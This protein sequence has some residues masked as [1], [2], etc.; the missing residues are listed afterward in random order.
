M[1]R[2]NLKNERAKRLCSLQAG[3]PWR[4]TKISRIRKHT[5]SICPS[6][7]KGSLGGGAPCVFSTRAV[8]KPWIPL[9]L[10]MSQHSIYCPFARSE[11][12]AL[13]WPSWHGCSRQVNPQPLNVGL[14]RAL[15]HRMHQTE[16]K[17]QFGNPV[18]LQRDRTRRR[19]TG[20]MA[21]AELHKNVG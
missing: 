1:K 7:L 16:S 17:R 8:G 10:L 19:E 3:G 11:G 4:P 21:E 6:C 5:E 9:E 13:H 20:T 2:S 12:P 14:K 15:L 18:E